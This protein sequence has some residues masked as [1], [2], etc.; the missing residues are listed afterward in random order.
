MVYPLS[1]IATGRHTV[2]VKAW[3]VHNNSGDGYTEFIVAETADLA[4][5]HVLNYPNPFTDNT[6]FWFE[7][8]RPGDLLDVKVEVF[9]VSGKR[10]IT[11]QQQVVTDGYRVDSITWDGRDAYGDP[12]GKGVYV[13][14]VSVKAASDNSS[15]Q[16]F[17]KLVILK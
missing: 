6:S 17:Q 7:H 15:A 1:D 5:S 2:S 16:E 3:D 13:Y 14:K 12:I 10:V 4:L 9:T 11:L 8:N